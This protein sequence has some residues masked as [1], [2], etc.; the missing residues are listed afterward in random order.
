MQKL[1]EEVDRTHVLDYIVPYRINMISLQANVAILNLRACCR[2]KFKSCSFFAVA[3]CLKTG[4]AQRDQL[5]SEW[6]W[7]EI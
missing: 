4:P 3:V 1:G 6:K 5:M 7:N 2:W